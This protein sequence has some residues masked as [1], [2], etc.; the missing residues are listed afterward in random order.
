MID[1]KMNAKFVLIIIIASFINANCQQRVDSLLFDIINQHRLE[2]GVGELEWSD[3]LYDLG[4]LQ[5]DY[6]YNIFNDSILPTEIELYH[7]QYDTIDLGDRAKN[8]NIN[9]DAIGEN[10]LLINLK[11][12]TDDEIAQKAFDTWFNSNIYSDD[13]DDPI[14]HREMMEAGVWEYGSIT[15]IIIDKMS[16][17][18]FDT[19]GMFFKCDDIEK[20][21]I[22]FVFTAAVLID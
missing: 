9:Y 2:I 22:V 21:L 15:S 20:E 10:L 5:T 8:K 4:K 6:H 1:Y 17:C 18:Y 11:D 7:V 19:Y 13:D 3:K 12:L 14:N 16:L